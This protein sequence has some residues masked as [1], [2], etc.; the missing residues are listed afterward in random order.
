MQ[1]IAL[2]ARVACAPFVDL[3]RRPDGKV[4]TGRKPQTDADDERPR[5]GAQPPVNAPPENAAHQNTRNEVRS[6]AKGQPL[7][8]AGAFSVLF[9]VGFPRLFQAV[10][11]AWQ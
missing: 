11:N 7:R 5:C 4:R 10:A 9:R 1:R 2:I 8:R 6:D 3:T